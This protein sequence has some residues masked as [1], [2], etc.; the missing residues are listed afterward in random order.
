M[1]D[2]RS[3]AV[4]SNY[5]DSLINFRGHLIRKLVESGFHVY[6]LAP[7][8]D[9]VA[10][11]K[12]KN[13]GAEPVPYKISRSG[14]NP[15]RDFWDTL[16]LFFL[17]RSLKPD[18]SLGYFIKPVIYGTIAAWLA[19][20]PRRF[21]MI[22]GLGFVFTDSGTD[23]SLKRKTLRFLVAKLYT[24][25]L[26]LSEKVFFLNPDDINEFVEKKVVSKSK[27]ICLGGIGVDL[28]EWPSAPAVTS[29]MTF[30]MVARLLKE[31]G[32]QDYA[33]AARIIKAEHP[34][35]RFILLGDLDPNPGA[36]SIE[37]I[38][39]W[40]QEGSIEW[41][42]YAEVRPW[43]RQASVFV[44]PSYREGVPRSTQEALAMGRPVITTDVPG[45]RETVV[46]GYNGV[47]VPVRDPYALAQAMQMFITNPDLVISMGENSRRLAE[48]RF[49]VHQVNSRILSAMEL[50]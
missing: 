39:A 22:E 6:A 15:L 21:V 45:C 49:D 40:V 2:L 32:V 28:Q 42:G 27:A 9:D 44:L 4:I 20:V 18:Y 14:M 46:S 5:A 23:L 13:L 48:S 31:K 7:D 1:T 24:L 25:A 8:L 43:L 19:G 29:P 36:L 26:S 34:E 50:S 12:I 38:N 35:V 16:R 10:S 33:S 11:G 41:P 37:Q 47:M 17:L 30:L 3:V